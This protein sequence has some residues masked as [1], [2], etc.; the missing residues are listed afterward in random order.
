MVH[1]LQIDKRFTIPQNSAAEETLAMVHKVAEV[2]MEEAPVLQFKHVI[3]IVPVPNTQY[4][5]G[6]ALSSQRFNVGVVHLFE[7]FVRHFHCLK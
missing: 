7:F 4:I 3:S 1:L 6:H 5:S 2:N